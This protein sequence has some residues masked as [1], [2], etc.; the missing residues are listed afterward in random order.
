MSTSIGRCTSIIRLAGLLVLSAL[1]LTNSSCKD[2]AQAQGSN[3]YNTPAEGGGKV[4]TCKVSG[5][6]AQGTQ[7]RGL[8]GRSKAAGLDGISILIP[9]KETNDN[10]TI[11]FS[12]A[13]TD[14]K[15]L[16]VERQAIDL[17]DRWGKLARVSGAVMKGDDRV[18][19]VT[20]WF[21]TVKADGTGFVEFEEGKADD[22]VKVVADLDCR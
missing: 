21:N 22:L 2:R 20:A 11:T 19:G 4:T 13:S 17:Y 12:S 3:T 15:D 14:T 7:V 8:T 9:A 5:H 6:K 16:K 18:L 1:L 10:A